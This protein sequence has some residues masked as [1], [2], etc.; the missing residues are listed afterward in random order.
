MP[1]PST[2]CI[3]ICI[4]DPPTGLCQGCGRTLDEIARWATLEE[5]DRLAIM[6]DLPDRLGAAGRID[7]RRQ[8]G[9][10]QGG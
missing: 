7:S 10:L 2:P 5:R 8:A 9:G 1:P 6:R 4:I 3:N